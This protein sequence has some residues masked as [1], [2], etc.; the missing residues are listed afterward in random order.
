[1]A[2]TG[3]IL[4]SLNKR[5]G[6]T[7]VY[8]LAFSS[9]LNL[10]LKHLLR[11]PR[12]GWLDDS[13]A[14][15]SEDTYGMPSWHA[16]MVTVF[17]LVLAIWIRKGWFWILA[18]LM[19]FLMAASRMYLGVHKLQDVIVGILL[20]ILIVVAYLLWQRYASASFNKRI[21]GQRLLISVS[22]PILLSLVYV[23]ALIIIGGPD[24][25]VVWSSFIETAEIESFTSV[26]RS[27]G[28]FLGVSIGFVLEGSR[29][30]FLVEGALWK[31][32]VRYILGIAV[33][34]V[35]GIVLEFLIPIEPVW[36]AGPLRGLQSLV[37]GL[38][39]SYYA[40]MV[41]VR[42]HLAE[43]QPEPEISLTL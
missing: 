1:L 5:L 22:I 42:L 34:A 11:D 25:Q 43:A 15:D 6:T 39:V 17:Y 14:L 27:F 38:W 33:A 8:L 3:L 19:I 20:G 31:R 24:S 37:L 26:F 18:L 10:I 41:F 4:W 35:L 9:Y 21:L 2:V 12:P 23:V 40:P 7:L 28:I 36:L 32:A 29:V 30:R 13:L 16:Q